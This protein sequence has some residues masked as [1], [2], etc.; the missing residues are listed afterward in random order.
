MTVQDIAQTV[1][2]TANGGQI[3]FAFNFRV[4]N[5][6]WL[7]I[8]FT[9]NLLAKN[10]NADQDNNPGGNIE[11]SIAPPN[12]QEITLTRIT[13][14]TQLLDYT[15]YDAFD[16]EASEDSLDK[17][18]MIIQDLVGNILGDIQSQIDDLIIQG[19]GFWLFDVFAG[20]RT[21]QLVDHLKMLKATGNGG[22]QT[23]TVP[24]NSVIPHPVGT[25]ISVLQKGTSVV[26]WVGSPGVTVNTPADNKISR[27]FGT[28]TFIKEDPDVWFVV[29]DIKQL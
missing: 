9:D 27:Q 15:R 25:Q 12:G 22:T 11:Y 21:L 1:T 13:P 18:T 20:D 10:L 6:S 3:I 14:I 4:D 29:G 5:E 24:L 8:S 23:I 7:D 17:L 19:D 16:S 2:Y 28:I 26:Q